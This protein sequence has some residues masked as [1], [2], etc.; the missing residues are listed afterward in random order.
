[1]PKKT[2]FLL[3]DTWDV[4]LEK[5]DAVKNLYKKV[6]DESILPT[7]NNFR[8]KGGLIIHSLS[9]GKA[10]PNSINTKE[11]INLS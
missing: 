6:M 10:Y 2:A 9:G 11:D 7:I 3:I 8:K 1:L 5:N 4:E